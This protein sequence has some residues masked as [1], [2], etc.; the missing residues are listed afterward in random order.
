METTPYDS[1]KVLNYLAPNIVVKF[2]KV[3]PMGVPNTGDVG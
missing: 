2:D 3:T 1:Q